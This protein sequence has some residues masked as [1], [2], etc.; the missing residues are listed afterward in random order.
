MAV[1]KGEIK[2]MVGHVFKYQIVLNVSSQTAWLGWEH[3]GI[4]NHTQK[5]TYRANV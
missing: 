3:S 4:R 2:L 5:N 1:I